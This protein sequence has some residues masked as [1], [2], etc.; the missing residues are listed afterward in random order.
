MNPEVEK[1][2]RFFYENLAEGK[3]VSGGE[4][5]AVAG[6]W[7]CRRRRRHR[8]RR[9]RRRRDVRLRPENGKYNFFQG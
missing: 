3:G 7:C 1:T 2:S 6:R 4:V 9:R 8:R 5:V